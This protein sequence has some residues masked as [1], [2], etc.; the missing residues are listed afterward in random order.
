MNFTNVLGTGHLAWSLQ[1]NGVR[2]GPGFVC[3]CPVAHADQDRWQAMD[4]KS[5]CKRPLLL[6]V[7]RQRLLELLRMT[8]ETCPIT[9]GQ[10]MRQT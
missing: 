7:D 8:L 3:Q 10:L 1:T 5:L 2:K 4:N 9:I 6:L